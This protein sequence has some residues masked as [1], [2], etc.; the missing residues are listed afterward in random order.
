MAFAI[1][2]GRR[3]FFLL[4]LAFVGGCARTRQAPVELTLISPHRDEIREETAAAFKEWFRNRTLD[5]IH[6]FR[7][8]LQ[9]W[10]EK[11]E[12]PRA[13]A[14][15]RAFADLTL[16]WRPDELTELRQAHQIWQQNRE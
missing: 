7:G 14:V 3:C 6:T 16:D 10:L 12:N 9:S 5:R 8:N 4:L 11:Q 13:E 15:Q 2:L 1:S